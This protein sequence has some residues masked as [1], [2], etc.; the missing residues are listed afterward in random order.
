M[1]LVTLYQVHLERGIIHR[2]EL[3]YFLKARFWVRCRASS[4]E[5]LRK[6]GSP[7]IRMRHIFRCDD[8]VPRC[9]ACRTSAGGE[10]GVVKLLDVFY[11]RQRT[12]GQAAS[13]IR[14]APGQTSAGGNSRVHHP[15]EPDAFETRGGGF[16]YPYTR[17]R[18]TLPSH[19]SS[20]GALAVGISAENSCIGSRGGGTQGV[21]ISGGGKMELRAWGLEDQRGIGG[22][23]GRG[24][25]AAVDATCAPPVSQSPVCFC[26]ARTRLN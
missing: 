3:S 20:I 14:S 22:D 8:S 11:Q 24:R 1:F 25:A 26:L 18:Q 5:E 7:Y 9:S 17:V 13:D 4:S 19:E 21:V 12:G 16:H 2:I 15:T 10:D 23:V 6:F